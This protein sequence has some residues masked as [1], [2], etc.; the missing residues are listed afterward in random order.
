MKKQ[1][2]QKN[3]SCCICGKKINLNEGNNPFPVRESSDWCSD[4]NRCCGECNSEFVIPFRRIVYH[5]SEQ[6]VKK[7]H[8]MLRNASYDSLVDIMEHIFS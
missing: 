6:D 7:A 5:F 4:K 3:I 2:N 1:K 8:N